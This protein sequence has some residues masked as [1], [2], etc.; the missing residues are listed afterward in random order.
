M[1]QQDTHRPRRFRDGAE[2]LAKAREAR[3]HRCLSTHRSLWG[4]PADEARA[5]PPRRP[6]WCPPSASRSRRAGWSPTAAGALHGQTQRVWALPRAT[7]GP[8]AR[9]PPANTTDLAPACSGPE[10]GAGSL[11]GRRATG[12]VPTSC[13]AVNGMTNACWDG[14]SA[15]APGAPPALPLTGHLQRRITGP[16]P[17]V[18]VTVFFWSVRHAGTQTGT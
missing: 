11:P 14:P 16:G 12:A 15:H 3:D 13:A 2:G 6:G 7:Q 9:V 8:G 4:C 5:G 10:Q 17:S 1:K 18:S